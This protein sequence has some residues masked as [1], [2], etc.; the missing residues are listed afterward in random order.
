MNEKC[1]KS[2]VF[3]NENI[4]CD[5]LEQAIDAD[6]TLPDFCPDVS[7]IFK[8][9]AIPR[10]V[11]KSLNGASVTIDGNV[12]VSILYCD[13]ESRFCSYEY[14][15]PF[16]KTVELSKDATGANVTVKVKC[17]Y[18]NCR[19]VTGRK[20]DIHGAVGI[21]LRVFKRKCD[22]IISDI[23]DSL[24]EV[25]RITSP[26]TVPMGYSEKYL[27]I[28]EDIPLTSA[29]MSI[30]SIL[31]TNSSVCIQETKI[32]NDKAVVKG[33]MFVSILYCP[34]GEG[35]P[36]IIKTTLPFS[37]IVD[38]DGVTD[39]CECECKA[40]ICVVDIKP[41]VTTSAE[42]RCFGINAKILLSCE[43]YCSN[44]I[45]MISDAFSRK[46]EADIKRK[47]L[48][49]EKITCTL[50]ERFNCKKSIDLDF[51]I[52]NI[53][54]VWCFVQNCYTK[55]ADGKMV[56]NGTLM[57]GIFACDENNIPVYFEKPTDFEYKIPFCES[58][59]TPHCDPQIEVVSCGFTIISVNK[60]EIHTE[61]GINAGIYETK[62]VSLVC[63][64]EVDEKKTIN[65]D[66]QCAMVIYFAEEND[67]LWDIAQK[68]SASVNEIMSINKM[69]DDN[70]FNGKMLLVPLI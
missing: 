38:I 49:I 57:T 30:E 66:K 17:D 59:G 48:S 37:Q 12:A 62:E 28:E 52:N 41:K 6:F 9:N 22:E 69:E 18:I 34:E 32:I 27:L 19:A 15:Y 55:F 21:Y 5:S 1:L 31:K 51:N 50:N 33:E 43:A 11:S 58:M 25:K 14:I 20:I 60:I 24:I 54:D 68:Y 45:P 46:F 36:Q 7:K 65:R 23:D 3:F 8:C 39:S 70:L 44:E 29:Q 56:V 61:L 2:D 47:N 67:S 40:E 35:I 4:F 42:Q 63:D 13:K 16:S 64:M 53:I 10:I 26:A